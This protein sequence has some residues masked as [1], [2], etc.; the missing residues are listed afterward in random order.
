[1]VVNLNIP[2]DCTPK[3]VLYSVNAP[4]GEITV[5]YGT[6]CRIFYLEFALPASGR[7]VRVE[8]RPGQGIP[9]HRADEEGTLSLIIDGGSPIGLSV[10]G[11]KVYEE[12]AATPFADERLADFSAPLQALADSVPKALQDQIEATKTIESKYW[13]CV[14]DHAIAGAELGG[15][16]GLVAGA[17]TGGLAGAASGTVAGGLGGAAAGFLGGA[18]IC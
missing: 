6:D 5:A 10:K 16:V 13:S 1:M 9:E 8:T 7:S 17:V 11:D 15:K 14:A 4:G 2:P 12:G 18:A 3:G